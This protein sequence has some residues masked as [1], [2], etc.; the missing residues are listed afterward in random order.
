MFALS[1]IPYGR[2]I[3]TIPRSALLNATS[4]GVDAL[5]PPRSQL[6][7]TQV[8]SLY[9]ARHRPPSKPPSPDFAPFIESLPRDF[10]S[11]PL[12]HGEAWAPI[13]ALGPS[14]L[15]LAVADVERRLNEDWTRVQ[16]AV[17]RRRES[18]PR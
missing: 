11:T 8:V 5:Q 18:C 14:S 9:L 15:Q 1:D 13:I 7:A 17:V 4:P 10:D 16:Q 6:A 3:L 12:T 2:T